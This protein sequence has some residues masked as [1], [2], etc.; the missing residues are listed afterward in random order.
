MGRKPGK[1]A[2][3]FSPFGIATLR[4]FFFTGCGIGSR[5]NP[6]FTTRRNLPD[7]LLFGVSKSLYW[8]VVLH[9]AIRIAAMTQYEM[10]ETI[11]C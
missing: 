11:L 8:E 9:E 5:L 10:N 6:D 3:A 2:T 4:A 1:A 7:E